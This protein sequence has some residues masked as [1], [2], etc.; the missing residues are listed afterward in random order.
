MIYG[1]TP[2][3]YCIVSPHGNCYLINRKIHLIN[4]IM[5]VGVT[6]ITVSSKSQTVTLKKATTILSFAL[7]I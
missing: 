1:E 5:V 4:R 6:H 3:R 7:R 2:F